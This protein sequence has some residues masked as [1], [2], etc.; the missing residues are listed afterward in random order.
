MGAVVPW[1]VVGAALVWL[2]KLTRDGWLESGEVSRLAAGVRLV[3]D[4]TIS[5]KQLV[6]AFLE[7]N[8]KEVRPVGKTRL[9]EQAAGEGE[10]LQ[11]CLDRAWRLCQRGWA[12]EGSP[13]LGGSLEP[14]QNAVVDRLR[15]RPDGIVLTALAMTVFGLMATLY[16]LSCG[17]APQAADTAAKAASAAPSL[18]AQAGTAS[19]AAVNSLSGMWKAFLPTFAGILFGLW[20]RHLALGAIGH[21]DQATSALDGAVVQLVALARR[22]GDMGAAANKLVSAAESLR[23]GAAPLQ[24]VIQGLQQAVSGLDS[25]RMVAAADELTRSTQALAD[26]TA[27]FGPKAKDLNDAAKA[28][29]ASTGGLAKAADKAAARLSDASNALEPLLEVA[30]PIRLSVSG[31]Y[32][33]AGTLG[34]RLDGFTRVVDGKLS[35]ALTDLAGAHVPMAARIGE[36]G[37]TLEA[38]AGTLDRVATSL[39]DAQAQSKQAIEKLADSLSESTAQQQRAFAD[40][41]L[42]MDD[43]L[44]GQRQFQDAAVQAIHAQ[45][46]EAPPV[47]EEL[48]AVAAGLREQLQGMSDGAAAVQEAVAAAAAATAGQQAQLTALHQAVQQMASAA[49]TMQQAASRPESGRGMAPLKGALED[50]GKQLREL[51]QQQARVAKLLEASAA[52]GRGEDED[53]DQV[54]VWQQ[55]AQRYGVTALRVLGW[56]VMVVAGSVVIG[57]GIDYGLVPSWAASLLRSMPWNF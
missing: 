10:I 47:V 3:A 8:Q 56:A 23:S 1:L 30:E 12:A 38:A 20:V 14:W 2:V 9:E 19:L 22:A 54:P 32:A 29:S 46:A 51:N 40:L 27:G 45:L 55:H 13:L 49:T 18:A 52:R 6:N 21:W 34:E 28:V 57:L 37:A 4:D 33:A 5:L 7:A 35:P 39:A 41:Q 50:I 11:Q 53:E 17:L 24:T 16:L 48:T 44:A 25:N 36:A 31:L 15:S 43:A 26:T 42:V